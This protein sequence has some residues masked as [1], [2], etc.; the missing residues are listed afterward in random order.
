[1][2][3]FQV[4]RTVRLQVMCHVVIRQRELLEVGGNR[5]GNMINRE[6]ST[7]LH[8]IVRR[9]EAETC[10]S[11]P[12]PSSI[13]LA[14]RPR[15]SCLGLLVSRRGLSWLAS[16]SEP[17]LRASLRYSCSLWATRWRAGWLTIM[18][19]GGIGSAPSCAP[20]ENSQ[21]MIAPPITSFN[22]DDL[23]LSITHPI[24]QVVQA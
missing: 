8:Q 12:H 11:A 23:I 5:E 13:V 21:A 2:F 14:C 4:L 10:F 15:R 6:E 24:H 1:M 16:L 22:L 19:T 20:S 9:A 3:G 18:C 7:G 17:L